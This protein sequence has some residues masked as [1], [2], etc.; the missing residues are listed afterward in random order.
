MSIPGSTNGCFLPLIYLHMGIRLSTSLGLY[1]SSNAWSTIP[2]LSLY[3]FFYGAYGTEWLRVG[4]LHQFGASKGKYF[5]KHMM[6][7]FRCWP[8][9]AA[10]VMQAQR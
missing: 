9:E 5:A 8:Y 2:I 10:R 7:Q 1:D 6:G 3:L 4:E